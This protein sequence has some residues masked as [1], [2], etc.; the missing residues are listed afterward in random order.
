MMS[1]RGRLDGT[2]PGQGDS[3]SEGIHGAGKFRVV[4][5]KDGGVECL[6]VVACG[7]QGSAE[8]VEVEGRRVGSRR[9]RLAEAG[10][11]E[12]QSLRRAMYG[13]TLFKRR[14]TGENQR[15]WSAHR[16]NWPT[17][18]CR[19][20]LPTYSDLESL[21]FGQVWGRRGDEGGLGRPVVG[22]LLDYSSPANW[23]AATPT[24]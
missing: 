1:V 13:Y 8:G 9:R 7:G 23:I 4:E 16:R 20:Y 21:G 3:R 2:R 12:R 17:N 14:P 19:A 6:E 10:P 15:K 5:M 24:G 11:W 22:W 18:S